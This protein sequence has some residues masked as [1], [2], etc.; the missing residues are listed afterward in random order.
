MA[1]LTSN[2]IPIRSEDVVK[3]TTG[4]GASERQ[5]FIA[6]VNRIAQFGFSPLSSNFVEG[7]IKAQPMKAF[8]RRETQGFTHPLE[9]STTLID[10]RI[11]LPITINIPFL[12]SRD[13]N[14]TLYEEIEQFFNSGEVVQVY[15]KARKNNNLYISAIPHEEVPDKFDSI[16]VDVTFTEIQVASPTITDFNPVNTEESTIVPRGV[17][18][19]ISANTLNI[20]ITLTQNI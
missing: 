2:Y 17:L 3:V 6:D 9:D 11:I 8:I 10:H 16:V 15:T 1:I 12:I 5:I 7:I 19:F 18:C 13:Y 14:N 20:D 4:Q